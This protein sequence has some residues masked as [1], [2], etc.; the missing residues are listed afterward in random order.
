MLQI[1]TGKLFS[2]GVGR[3]NPLTGILYTNARLGWNSRL[4][5]LAGVLRTVGADHQDNACIFDMEER[6]ELAVNEPGVLVSH[7]VSPFLDDFAIVATFGLGA[8]FSRRA[9]TVRALTGS[10]GRRGGHHALLDGVY[11]ETVSISDAQVE[12]FA[13]FVETLLAL[14]RRSFL[15]AMRAMRTFVSGLH[16][17]ADDPSLAYT[18]MVA[19]AESLAQKFDDYEPQWQDLESRKRVDLDRA[20]ASAD[21]DV[22]SALRKAV[23]KHEHLLL[24]R[25]Y[26]EFILARIDDGFFRQAGLKGRP[27]ARWELGPALRLAY[28]LRSA[29]I[30]ELKTLPDILTMGVHHYESVNVER[31]PALTLQGLYRVTRHT[32]RAFVVEQPKIAFEPYNYQLEQAGIVSL[33]WAAQYWIGQ[34]LTR[35]AEA[36]HRFEGALEIVSSQLMQEP[37]SALFPDMRPVLAEVERLLHQ[38]APADRA[39][40]LCLHILYNTRISPAFRSPDYEAFLEEHVEE[41]SRPG[42]VTLTLVPIYGEHDDDAWSLLDHQKALDDYF[43]QRRKAKGLHAPRVLEAAMCLHLAEKYRLAGNIDIARATISRAL[44]AHPGVPALLVLEAEFDGGAPIKWTEVLL[45]PPKAADVED[46]TA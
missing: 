1:N 18:L 19:A 45:T 6:I 36:L 38:A 4:E 11:D 31:E 27:V 39:A 14:E 35:P 44:E 8:I 28:N 15:G 23:L 9:E 12:D 22:Q 25:R 26:R 41:A 30:H 5:T 10:E 33:P 20:I 40:M 17:L 34:P 29:H 21:A 2:R 3:T 37:N 43:E 7:G 46:G 32:I 16:R 42:P 13:R 24:G